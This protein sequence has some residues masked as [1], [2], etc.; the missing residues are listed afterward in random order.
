VIAIP[1][2]KSKISITPTL[3]A[4]L[5]ACLRGDE[6][7]TGIGAGAATS[8]D[9]PSFLFLPL[10]PVAPVSGRVL[11]LLIKAKYQSNPKRL[12]VV[13]AWPAKTIRAWRQHLSQQWRH[14]QDQRRVQWV[15]QYLG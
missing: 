4:R 11:A 14:G 1:A 6:T 13:A 8:S 3:H 9:L 2:P 12:D 7:G 15:P 5:L 10:V